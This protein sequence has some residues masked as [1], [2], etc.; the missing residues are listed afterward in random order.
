MTFSVV[1]GSSTS[2]NTTKD[3]TL[4]PIACFTGTTIILPFTLPLVP[5][6]IMRTSPLLLNRT[7]EDDTKPIFSDTNAFTY[8]TIFTKT[9]FMASASYITLRLLLWMPLRLLFGLLLRQ[10]LW[11]VTRMS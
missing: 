4:I 9:K 11:L 2:S 3:R 7:L 8:N 10:L 5:I 6:V 1:S